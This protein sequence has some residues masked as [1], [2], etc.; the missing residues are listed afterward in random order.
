MGGLAH[1]DR[2][3][4]EEESELALRAR[5]AIQRT[6]SGRDRSRSLE[7]RIRSLQEEAAG[8]RPG[9]LPGL[10]AQLH[11][12]KRQAARQGRRRLP[13][14]E[15][16][17]FAH[18][19]LLVEGETRD[20]LLGF[21]TFIDSAAGVTI[22]DWR[23]APVA[24]IFFNYE[25]GDVYEH[26]VDGRW[27]SGEVV[28]R[29]VLTFDEGEVAVID[30]PEGVLRRDEQG[31][32]T[33]DQPAE[34]E[35]LEGG[36][37]RSGVT[38]FVGT[39]EAGRKV[40]V[41]TALLD[42][43][44][45]EALHRDP[46]RPLLLLGGAGCGK[47]TVAMHRLAS[48]AFQDARFFR[49]RDMAVI[50]P[51]RG[52]VKLT[53]A[54][55]REIGME[56]VAVATFDDWIES[57]G[58]RLLRGLPRTVC[59]A[60]PLKVS[61]F[62]RHPAVREVLHELLEELASDLARDLDKELHTGGVLQQVF[63]APQAHGVTL[64][65]R[66][67]RAERR[68]TRRVSP[69]RAKEVRA[70]LRR[71]RRQIGRV[72]A[73][74]RRL[75]LDRALLQRAVDRSEGELDSSMVEAVIVHTAAQLA[76]TTEQEYAGVEQQRLLAL[77]ERSIDEGTPAE[78]AGTIDVEDYALLFD[79]LHLKT[80]SL[81]TDK[82]RFPA[83]CHLVIDEAQDLASVELATL[84]RALRED[85]SVT[86][87]GDQA[88]QI[89]PA[90]AFGDWRAVLQSLGV[91][92]SEPIELQ[93]SYRCPRP[94][95]RYGYDVLGSLAPDRP[96]QASRDGAAVLERH[97]PNEGHAAIFLSEALQALTQREPRA[98]VAVIARTPDSAKRMAEALSQAL[99]VRTVLDG[100]FEFAPGI[101]VTDIAQVK[102]LEFDYVVI[103]DASATRYPDDGECRRALHVAVTRA[104]YQL[105]VVSS[106]RPSPLLPR[107]D[108]EGTT[109][110]SP[111]SAPAPGTG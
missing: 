3:I 99:Q 79:L 44:Q 84:G 14:A 8:A 110:P 39:G 25:E 61:R 91:E 11:V 65:A 89:D 33:R 75:L 68:L 83:Y 20:V 95:A 22:V 23:T 5:E 78:V 54:I 27:L 111:S 58:K 30:H 41:V 88:Q 51:E 109:E 2:A 50:V 42:S 69:A 16:P 101:D 76:S 6:A 85:A 13:S 98:N 90:V 26:E 86:V 77:D 40:P 100:D 59:A 10:L 106:G 93:T 1:E 21:Q 67:N 12:L 103:P 108:G 19:R 72:A 55:L 70:V 82:G 48:L 15:V 45:Y 29:R 73:D 104:V 47:T 92:W 24:R 81:S 18:L 37:G 36:A 9:D 52:L 63:T 57:L 35:Q 94:I 34:R 38:R 102:G 53:R 66:M 56:R 43:E 49:A 28:A 46:H 71:Y 62:K 7:Q 97:F 17:Y 74:R 107:R 105:C 31:R 64:R 80:G 4:V 87:A 32:W 96:P 60:T